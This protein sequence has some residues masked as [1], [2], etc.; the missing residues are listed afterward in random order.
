M[1]ADA[2]ESPTASIN[3]A[4][5]GIARH[6]TMAAADKASGVMSV[7]MAVSILAR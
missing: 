2:T 3:G 4:R 5:T 7:F 1:W 6:G